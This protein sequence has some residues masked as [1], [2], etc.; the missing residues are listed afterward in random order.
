MYSNLIYIYKID[1]NLFTIYHY[2]NNHRIPR[3][4]PKRSNIE[5]DIFIEILIHDSSQR[6]K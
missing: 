4:L 5:F 2:N 3:Y 1:R 6:Q